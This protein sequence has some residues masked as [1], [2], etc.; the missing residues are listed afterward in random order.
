M[1]V[2]LSRQVEVEGR[3]YT[4]IITDEQEPVGTLQSIVGAGWGVEVREVAKKKAGPKVTA[5]EDVSKQDEVD[6]DEAAGPV[7]IASLEISKTAIAALKK[8][9]IATVDQAAQYIADNNGELKIKG[10]SQEAVK[11][12][13]AATNVEQE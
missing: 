11:V 7:A 2:Q 5:P 13:T 1:K 4:G 3:V 6:D 8:A 12:I 9:G 10:V